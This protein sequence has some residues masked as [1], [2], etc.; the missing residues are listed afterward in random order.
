M[1]RSDSLNKNDSKQQAV[2]I[3][4]VLSGEEQG[5]HYQLA[6]VQIYTELYARGTGGTEINLNSSCFFFSLTVV[7]DST[8]ELI[9]S[10]HLQMCLFYSP[11]KVKLLV[12]ELKTL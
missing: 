10:Y 11:W 2:L 1:K 5:E 4:D 8:P 6:V 12:K 7:V 3:T 9:Q